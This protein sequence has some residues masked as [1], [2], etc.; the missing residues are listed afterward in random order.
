M[1]S[2]VDRAGQRYGAL[3]VIKPAYRMLSSG[4]RMPAWELKCDCGNEVIAMTVNLTK[5]KH[6]SCGCK[7]A[8]TLSTKLATHGGTRVGKHW[9]EYSVWNQMR[10]RCS[11][12][13]AP[14]Y[15]WYGAKGVRVCE[16]WN[17]PAGGFAAFIADMGRRP[18]PKAT[19]DR[20]DVFADYGPDNCRW[21]TWKEQANNRRNS[22]GRLAA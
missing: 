3:T 14:N 20:I 4:R 19:I 22:K 2:H 11:K 18:F 8:E 5:G 7:K 21:A 6:M 9:P 15:K 10:Q 12:L 16:R 17:D 13:Y 1:G